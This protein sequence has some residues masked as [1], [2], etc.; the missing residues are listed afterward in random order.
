M[1]DDRGQDVVE[2][3]RDAAGQLADRLHLGRLRHL[4]LQPDLLGIVLQRQED[5]RV[6]QPARAGD[7]QDDRL[8][9]MV[10]EADRHVGGLGRRAAGEA[11]HRIGDRA[12][13]LAHHQV[14]GIDRRRGRIDV[15]RA[16]EGVVDLQEAPVAPDQR[17]AEREQVDEAADV[18]RAAAGHGGRVLLPVEQQEQHRAVLPLLQRHRQQAQR[19][20][21]ARLVTRQPQPAGGVG[22][23]QFVPCRRSIAVRAVAERAAG[24]RA[25]HRPGVPRRVDQRRHDARRCRAGRRGRR[26]ARRR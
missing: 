26:S 21:G 15:R 18:G 12:L 17:Q 14:A 9:G 3:V 2:I 16:Q 25:G 5:R 24:E 20:A 4:A 22:D 23:Q 7:G 13:V 6:A 1:A 10:L 8:V 11:A 19:P